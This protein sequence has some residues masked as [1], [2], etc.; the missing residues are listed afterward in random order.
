[1]MFGQQGSAINRALINIS[2]LSLNETRQFEL[3]DNKLLTVIR[4]KRMI[5]CGVLCLRK[6][7][8]QSVTFL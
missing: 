3:S 7:T 4:K 5:Y 8:C 1:M 6:M 2:V